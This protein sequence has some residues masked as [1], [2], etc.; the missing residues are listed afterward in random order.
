MQ[1]AP[2]EEQ[3]AVQQEARRF[4]AAE[5][6]RERRV[7]WDATREGYDPAFWQAVARLGW[8]GYGLPAAHGGQAASLLDLGLLVEELGRAAA[9]FGVFAQIA[10]GL[11]LAALGT[12]AQKR[13]W[14][15]AIARGEKLVTLA[16][17]E[18][19]A[20]A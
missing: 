11:G 18:E 3:Q 5:I 15:P 2:T 10:G 8:L 7:A 19:G 12:P 13:A 14:L 16:V 20:S 1:L 4:L 6:D 9:P 17:A